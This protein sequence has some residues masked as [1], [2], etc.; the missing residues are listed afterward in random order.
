MGKTKRT[1]RDEGWVRGRVGGPR[2]LLVI[3]GPQAPG[4]AATTSK[5]R[6]TSSA[7]GK[8]RPMRGWAAGQSEEGRRRDRARP[9]AADFLRLYSRCVLQR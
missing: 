2:G 6:Y 9:L 5:V 7:A 4:L 3:I 8:C 1:R